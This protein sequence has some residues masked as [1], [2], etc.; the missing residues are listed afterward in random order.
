MGGDAERAEL[1]RWLAAGA[2]ANVRS[3]RHLTPPRS[4]ICG[5]GAA[6]SCCGSTYRPRGASRIFW[7]DLSQARGS[8]RAVRARPV[9][10]R[11]QPYSLSMD[12]AE[13]ISRL[14]ASAGARSPPPAPPLHVALSHLLWRSRGCRSAG[15]TISTRCSISRSSARRARLNPWSL[16]S[17]EARGLGQVVPAT[18]REIAQRLG[19]KNFDLDMLFLP[20]VS[21]RFGVWYFAQDMKMFNNETHLCLDGVQRGRGRTKQWQRPDLDL[22]VK[23]SWRAR[24]TSTCGSCTTTAALQSLY[25]LSL[26]GG[27]APQ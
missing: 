25:T 7:G 2:R 27:R 20:H 17:A 23:R 5:S 14:A 21:V 12:C 13:K 8:S 22:A 26:C 24:L 1:E 3:R 11:P 16:S 18:G 10:S 9:F 15:R 19:V 6:L 4:K